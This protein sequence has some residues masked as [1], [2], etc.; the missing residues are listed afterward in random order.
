MHN[1]IKSLFVYNANPVIAAANQSKL[2]ENLC[3]EDLFMIVSEVFRL[4]LVIIRY[5]TADARRT[6]RSDVAGVIAISI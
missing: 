6:K 4:T 1:P 2:L 3:R 5:F